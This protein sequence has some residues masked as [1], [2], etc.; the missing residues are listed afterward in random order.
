MS[1][2]SSPPPQESKKEHNVYKNPFRSY[3]HFSLCES[4]KSSN[5]K[6]SAAVVIGLR[7]CTGSTHIGNKV[8]IG[9]HAE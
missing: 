2:R 5:F 8:Y 4:I 7:R 9:L 1:A 6:N 3:P